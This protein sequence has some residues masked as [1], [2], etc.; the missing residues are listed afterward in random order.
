MTGGD[1]ST[2]M[3]TP[4]TALR[5]GVF[6]R[7]CD[8]TGNASDNQF[9]HHFAIP[10]RPQKNKKDRPMWGEMM[11]HTVKYGEDPPRGDTSPK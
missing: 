11:I 6:A 3:N 9:A 5:G 10:S 2:K 7:K 8:P 4:S 1:R